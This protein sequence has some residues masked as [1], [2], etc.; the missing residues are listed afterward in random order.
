MEEKEFEDRIVDAIRAKNAKKLLQRRESHILHRRRSFI[1]VVSGIAAAACIAVGIVHFNGISAYKSYGDRHYSAME[2]HAA[3]GG[4]DADSLLQAAHGQIGAAEY[5]LAYENIDTAIELLQSEQFDL[6]S[7]EGQYFAAI[8]RQTL[9]DARWLKAVAYM[10][11]GKRHKAKI[12]LREIATGDGVHK[13]EA[14][15]ILK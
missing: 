9:D 1:Q 8:N 13:T 6:T 11:Q 2:L 3:R 7:E 15:K 12:L 5:N 14:Q 4:G 10:K